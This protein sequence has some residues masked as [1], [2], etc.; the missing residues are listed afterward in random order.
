[1]VRTI[2]PVFSILPSR[3]NKRNKNKLEVLGMRKKMRTAAVVMAGIL[4]LT[5]LA[6]CGGSD[7]GSEGKEGGGQGGN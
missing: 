1:M 2:T 7:K 6:A 4:G 3:Y 5:G